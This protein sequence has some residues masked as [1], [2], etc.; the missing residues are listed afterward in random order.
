[1]F[2]SMELARMPLSHNDLEVLRVK[3]LNFLPQVIES[4][5]TALRLKRNH[6]DVLGIGQRQVVVRIGT[7]TVGGKERHFVVKLSRLET[8]AMQP[9]KAS[10]FF[11]PI[12]SNFDSL[13]AQ[14]ENAAAFSAY[15]PVAMHYAI[16]EVYP[17]VYATLSEDLTRG[18]KYR[19]FEAHDFFK[20]LEAGGKN[21]P[22][23]GNVEQLK[24]DFENYLHRLEQLRDDNFFF[25]YNHV[26]K[27]K[28]FALRRAFHVLYDPETNSA[29]LVMS[30]LD[31][32]RLKDNARAQVEGLADRMKRLIREQQGMQGPVEGRLRKLGEKPA[33]A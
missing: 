33:F 11:V 8:S 16:G 13:I 23:P 27:D 12:R 17:G 21:F 28:R 15:F 3:A 30:D 18:G 26:T 5:K 31:H 7:H 6:P 9:I 1:M 4:G 32:L 10:R 2:M 14:E 19:V 20:D 25:A 24:T 29:A 22:S